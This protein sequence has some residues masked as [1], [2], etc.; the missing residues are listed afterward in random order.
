[1]S[2]IIIVPDIMLSNFIAA[3]VTIATL[4]VSAQSSPS[5]ISVRD[6]PLTG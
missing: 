6:S 5:G 2:A 1:M 4:S 3:G